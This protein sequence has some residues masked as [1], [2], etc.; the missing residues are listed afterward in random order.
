M[1]SFLKAFSV[2]VVA[3]AFPAYAADED[4]LPEPTDDIS[5]YR[6]AGDWTIF[7]NATR[8]SCFIT[9]TDESN[10]TAVQIGLTK[11]QQAG[12]IGVFSKTADIQ[13]GVKDI[14]ILVNDNIYVGKS[15]AFSQSLNDGYKGG[16]VLSN[17]K[18]LRLDLEKGGTMVAFPDSP[19]MVII[20]LKGAGNAIYE[21]RECNKKLQ[22]E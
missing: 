7:Q 17:N 5:S 21:G 22:G 13:E 3:F 8:G 6:T 11:D 20:D 16:Y 14:S 18:Q 1:K 12:Y 4:I 10:G 9:R 15:K 2:A 19:Y